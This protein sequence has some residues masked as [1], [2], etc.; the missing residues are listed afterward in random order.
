MA[1]VHYGCTSELSCSDAIISKIFL[2][3][4][5]S[6]QAFHGMSIL[7]GDIWFRTHWSWHWVV[8]VRWRPAVRYI[9][10]SYFRSLLFS[11]CFS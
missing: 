3:L 5:T 8:K 4:P 2:N 1:D 7:A 9:D 10:K 6:N 11:K